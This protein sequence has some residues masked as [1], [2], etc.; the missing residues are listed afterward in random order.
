MF[1]LRIAFFALAATTSSRADIVRQDP[2]LQRYVDAA[3]AHNGELVARGAE[4]AGKAE[5]VR[6]AF[7][8]FLPSVTFDVRY[9]RVWGGLDLGELINPAYAALNQAVGEDRFPT[10]L[11]LRLPLALDAKIRVAQPLYVPQIG[12]AYRLSKLAAEREARERR[13]ARREIIATVA[14]LYYTHARAA[15]L[16]ALL[17]Q[18]RALLEENLQVSTS[19]VGAAKATND[20]VLRARAELAA[21]DQQ[22]RAA[23]QRQR[24]AARALAVLVGGGLER[25]RAPVELAVP[26][27]PPEI[28]PLIVAAKRQRGELGLLGLA[29]RATREQRVL[30]TAN[31][32]PTLSLAFDLGVQRPNLGF[33]ADDAYA[34]I[35]LVGSWNLFAGGRDR[36]RVRQR[37]HE[38]R[39]IE[40]RRAELVDQIDAD[41][42]T[43]WE[44]A[45]VAR[46]AVDTAN[47]RIS[48]TD[49]AYRILA[50]RYAVSDV[51]QLEVLVAENALIEAR[52]E[53]IVAITDLYIR[54][55]ELD[56]AIASDE[57][58]P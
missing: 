16:A 44:A 17:R 46:Q 5:A 38:Q 6:E 8:N 43:A 39:A 36:S 54:L 22:L 32:R 13:I 57:V 10:D 35:S 19:L 30:A 20:V 48:S 14:T 7:A 34:A 26:A 45:Q 50:E 15:L 47:D 18:T 55:V 31:D 24:A 33:S 41:V 25:V 2:V 29:E 42:T 1:R 53:R 12:S 49:A 56:R 9:S 3:L 4:V 11:H 23:E 52:T 21:H 40:A 51:P 27:I 58:S 28:K 37:E